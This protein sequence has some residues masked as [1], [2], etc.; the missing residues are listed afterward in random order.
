MHAPD[1]MHP[2]VEVASRMVYF[3]HDFVDDRP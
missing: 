2:Q 3:H 1:P